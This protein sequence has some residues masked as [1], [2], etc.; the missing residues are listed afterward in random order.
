VCGPQLSLAAGGVSGAISS[1]PPLE[2]RRHAGGTHLALGSQ[3]ELRLFELLT[4]FALGQTSGE[5]DDVLRAAA[6]FVVY[7]PDENAYEVGAHPPEVALFHVLTRRAAAEG[8]AGPPPFKQGQ[9][10][11][12]F[13]NEQSGRWELLHQPPGVWRFQLT[14]SL[15]LGGSAAA[16]L[17]EWDSGSS[18]YVVTGVAL[19]V[20]DAL[21][22]WEGSPGDRA[23]A[24]YFA[25]SDRWEVVPHGAGGAALYR[26]EL[27]AAKGAA[28]E[29]AL[30]KLVAWDGDEYLAQGDDVALVQS[31]GSWSGAVGRRGWATLR[32]DRP[33]AVVDET[34]YPAYEIVWLEN[35]ARFVEFTL[36]E[37][38]GETT[39][40][41]ATAAVDNFFHGVSPGASVT[42]HDPLALFA[43]ALDGAKG[44]ATLDDPGGEYHVLACE[45]RAAMCRGQI[46]GA[47]TTSNDTHPVDNVTPLSGQSPVS[48]SADEI[49][50]ENL[51]QWSAA[52]NAV[53]LF[54]WD[55]THDEWILVQVECP[56]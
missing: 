33:S 17:V 24:R 44:T 46:K 11:W 54:A 23:Y 1:S 43:R 48:S 15:A 56:A 27:T 19:T 25:D 29:I 13:F 42:V 21:G 40:G 47:M 6:A 7:R 52:D 8:P 55:E 3:P 28:D 41:Q 35:L 31:I 16:V 12:G 9:R 18:Q 38:L 53:C 37:D 45:Q 30:G 36:E 51:F 22:V 4:D 34:T 14:E 39:T 10:A 50:V 2:L 5:D 26:F 32:A 49:T 20:H